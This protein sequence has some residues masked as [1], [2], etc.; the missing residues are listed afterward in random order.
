MFTP[1]AFLFGFLQ[2]FA[3]GPITLYGIREGLNPK[4]GFW[5]QI[6]VTF[7][8]TLVDAVYLTMATNGVMQFANYDGVRL[9]MWVVAAYMLLNMGIDSLRGDLGKKKLQHV[10]RHKLHFFDSNFFKGFFMCMT[11]PLAITYAVIVVGGLYTN[12]AAT[13]APTPFALQVALGG[14]TTSLIIVFSTLV[15]RH[16]FHQWM[17]KK[18]VMVGSM[19]L[20]GY[21]AFFSWKA[22]N[23]I[24]PTVEAF[25]ASLLGL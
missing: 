10:H 6:Q 13:V 15:L 16:L 20:I 1:E 9:F 18:L 12:F 2:G 3:I 17:L 7:G 8:A 22:I 11:S 24:A 19:V 23:E 14:F 21:G 4:R 5:F 25:S